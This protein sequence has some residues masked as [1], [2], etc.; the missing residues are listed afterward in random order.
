MKRYLKDSQRLTAKFLN[1]DSNELLFEI[2]NR[3]IMDIGELFSDGYVNLLIK[4]SIKEEE[5][6]ENV[7][8]LIIGEYKLR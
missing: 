4:E 3:N 8:V 5:L 7:I 6:P 2:K 1:A